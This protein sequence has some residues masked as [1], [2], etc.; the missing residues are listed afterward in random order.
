M[1]ELASRMNSFTPSATAAISRRV[2]EL[3]AQGHDV[4]SFSIG[5]PGFIPPHEIY[6]ETQK[7]TDHTVDPAKSYAPARGTPA[8]LEA[9]CKR[10][11][12]DGFKGYTP[13]HIAAS[14]GGKG[15]LFISLLL[16]ADN[17]AKVAY[18]T[19]HWVSYPE[20]IKLAGGT[21][22]SITCPASQNYKILPEQLRETLQSGV[23]VFL[24]NNPNNPTGVVYTKEEISALANVL[25]DFP[26]VWILSDDIYDKLIY[27]GVGFHHLVQVCPQLQSRTFIIQSISK[28]YGL[29]G[30]RLG[31]VAAPTPKLA[32]NLGAL[33]EQIMMN[34][35]PISMAVGAV[36][37]N[38]DLSFLDPIRTDFTQKRDAVMATLNTLPDV[39]CPHPQGAFYAFPNLSA[40]IGGEFDGQ[41]I[42][43]DTM[44]CKLLLEECGVALVPG[45]S[46]G[47]SGCVRFSYTVPM[48]TL[49]QGLQRFD[50]FMRAIR[51]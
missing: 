23:K 31:T 14:V 3:R 51:R 37:Y 20:I 1:P 15:G 4:I 24:F 49:Q 6:E 48:E 50:A 7:L 35:P 26:D 12:A 36:C 32:A 17:G 27:D 8:L 33:T 10:L 38:K 2:G 30:W 9:C 16:L 18:G 34:I 21:P 44:L 40:Y 43:D 25:T 28:N 5:V 29:P 19:P 41:K 13:D 39:S 45:S 22:V 47:A 42:S 11:E 46:S